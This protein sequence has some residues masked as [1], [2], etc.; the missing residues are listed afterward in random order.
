MIPGL[1][2]QHKRGALGRLQ[3]SFFGPTQPFYVRPRIPGAWGTFTTKQVRPAKRT[4]KKRGLLRGPLLESTHRDQLQSGEKKIEQRFT[5]CIVT[6][7]LGEPPE[8]VKVQTPFAAD[9]G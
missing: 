6:V 2:N 5:P 9:C 4:T 1:R 8:A 3:Q 7:A